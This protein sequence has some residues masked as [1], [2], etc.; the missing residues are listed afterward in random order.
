MAIAMISKTFSVGTHSVTDWTLDAK[1]EDVFGLD[2]FQDVSF[3]L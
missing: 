2:V 1:R 3:D